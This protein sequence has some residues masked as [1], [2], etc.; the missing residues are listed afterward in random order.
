MLRLLSMAETK[1]TPHIRADEEH[2]QPVYVAN[3]DRYGYTRRNVT[4]Y[5]SVIHGGNSTVGGGGILMRE[6][7]KV[8]LYNV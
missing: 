5:G 6:R 7:S 2:N 4:V 1:I 3:A 8:Y